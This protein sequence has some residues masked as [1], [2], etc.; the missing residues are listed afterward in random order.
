MDQ[1][2]RNICVTCFDVEIDFSKI[3]EIQYGIVGTEI[4]PSTGKKHLQCYFEL[5]KQMRFNAVKILPEGCH[6]ENRMG[7]QQQAIAYCKKDNVYVEFGSLKKSHKLKRTELKNLVLTGERLSTIVNNNDLSFN[8]TKFI[9]KIKQYEKV[10]PLKKPKVIWICG[11]PGS[12][13]TTKAFELAGSDYYCKN[14]SKWWDGYD[15]LS[16]LVLND[17][18]PSRYWTADTTLRILGGELERIEVK[19]SSMWLKPPETIIITNCNRPETVWQNNH[20][21][22][23]IKQLLRRISEIIEVE[24]VSQLLSIG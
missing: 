21:D 23:Q 4:C 6:L 9:E 15:E 10:P 24:T 5:T 18:R 7:T 19:G 8:D 20:S 3:P 11:E 12:G 14:N 22:E 1:R 16:V 17:W 2:L 13:K